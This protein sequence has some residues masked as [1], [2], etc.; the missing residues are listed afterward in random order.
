MPAL[1]DVHPDAGGIFDPRTTVDV[2]TC[3]VMMVRHLSVVGAP[4]LLPDF[5]ALLEQCGPVLERG[6][7]SH[8]KELH[9]PLARLSVP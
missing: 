5:W 6:V 2:T 3:S 1:E 8:P 9:A 7:R 4:L